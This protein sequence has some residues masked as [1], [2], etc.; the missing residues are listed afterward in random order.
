MAEGVEICRE[1]AEFV[2]TPTVITRKIRKEGVKCLIAPMCCSP[3]W[4]VH[5]ECYVIDKVAGEP[6]KTELPKCSVRDARDAIEQ[7][8]AQI[9]NP[10]YILSPG[11]ATAYKDLVELNY[12]SPGAEPIPEY[13]K[14]RLLRLV[15][16][17]GIPFERSDID[18][19]KYNSMDTFID[20][21]LRP[22]TYGNKDASAITHDD[23][24]I[25]ATNKESEALDD[26]KCSSLALWAHELTHVFQNRRDGRDV[27]FS[28]YVSDAAKYSYR[29]IPYEKEAYAVEDT[30]TSKYC[31]LLLQ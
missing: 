19:A 5:P 29:D 12:S 9:K 18:R 15:G 2:M 25:F 17:P 21:A 13:I 22:E 4:S 31:D 16:Q 24:I 8:V 10:I 23:L 30:V 7:F 3:T 11:I 28:K 27:F 1:V 26:K 20:K 6:V 14:V